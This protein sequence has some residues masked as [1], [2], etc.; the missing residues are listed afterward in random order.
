MQR[1]R[2][3]PYRQ[4]G[5]DPDVSEHQSVDVLISAAR[6]HVLSSLFRF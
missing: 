6:V 3:A 2:A 5:G 1:E 4:P